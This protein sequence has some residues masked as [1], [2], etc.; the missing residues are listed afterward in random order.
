[1]DFHA[2]GVHH[3]TLRDFSIKKK[4]TLRDFTNSTGFVVNPY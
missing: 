1:M 4:H 2:V 3:N